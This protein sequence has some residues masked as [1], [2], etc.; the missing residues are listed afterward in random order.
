MAE[1][2]DAIEATL[3]DDFGIR[4]AGRRMTLPSVAS[5]VAFAMDAALQRAGPDQQELHVLGEMNKTIACSVERA[6]AE[7]GW[8]P[9]PG[10]REGMRRS[11]DWCLA[12]GQAL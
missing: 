3:R 5:D 4:V 8:R 6:T 2:V 10:L 12:N 11:V 1:I 7:L 9:G